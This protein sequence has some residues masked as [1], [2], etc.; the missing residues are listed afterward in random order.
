MA[1][2]SQEEKLQ[3]GLLGR[4]ISTVERINAEHGRTYSSYVCL[5]FT[6]GSKLMLSGGIPWSPKPEIEEMKKAHNF[7]S[8]DDI[9]NAVREQEK[10]KHYQRK[11]DLQR[12]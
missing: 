7:F 2:K 5:T 9:A 4:M 1:D 10:K 11:V 3:D 12:K 8:P 6:D